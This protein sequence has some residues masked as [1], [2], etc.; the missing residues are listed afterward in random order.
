MDVKTYQKLPSKLKPSINLEAK[1]ISTK[2]E[3]INRVKRITR[4]PAFVTLKEYKD[5]FHSNP[6]CRLISPS[7]GELGK[8]SKQ[9]VDKN[10]L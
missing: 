6:T 10:K 5:N 7:K 8:F 3:I 2:L 9:L 4:T 1:S